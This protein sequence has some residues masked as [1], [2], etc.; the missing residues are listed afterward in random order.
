[1]NRITIIR[2]LIP[3][4]VCKRYTAGPSGLEKSVVAHVTEG[5]GKGFD[6]PDARAMVRVL[7]HVTSARNLVLVSGGWKNDSGQPFRVVDERKL[8][9]ILKGEVGRVPGG[10]IEH[11]GELISARLKRGIEAS[12]W[13][14]LDAD[15]PPGIPAEW[16]AMS[17][18][19]RLELWDKIIPGISRAERVELRGSSARVLNGS[20]HK[21]KTHA[22]VRVNKPANIGLMKAWIGVEMVNR[23]LSFQFEKKSR[24]TPDKT[25]GIE[26]RSVF[27]LAVFDTGRIVFCSEPE[28]DAP[29]YT[30]DDAGIEIV[31]EG[32][33]EVD[34]A[35][36]TTP[37]RSAL[38]EYKART[39]IELDVKVKD[40]GYLSVN[41]QGLLRHDTEITVRGVTKN[42]DEWV[43]GM[44]PGDKL[45]CESPFRESHSEAALVRLLDDGMPLVHDVGNGTTYTL[46]PEAIVFPTM[47]EFLAG[48]KG[49]APHPRI[50]LEPWASIE[51]T[52]IK[53]TVEGMLPAKGFAALYGQPGSY[54][55][56]VALYL[57]AMI[58]TGR[59]AFGRATQAG[60]IVYIMGEGGAGLRYRRDALTAEYGLPPDVP[61]HFIRAQLDLRSKTGDGK[62]LVEA[63]HGQGLQPSLVVIDTLAR[64]F[65]GG[66]E[67][68]SEDMGAFITQVGAVQE[69]LKCGILVVHHSGKDDARG[70]RGHSSLFGA[71]DAELEVKKQ[72][73]D[74]SADRYGTLAV[75]KQKDGEDGV[76]FGFR[77]KERQVT[78][79]QA[80]L[81]L[82][83]V[84]AG[85]AGSGA[86][87]KGRRGR[88]PD[89]P[90]I[91]LD[92]L[93]RAIDGHGVRVA[94]NEIPRDA[95]VVS[96]TLWRHTYNAMTPKEGEAARK[97][98]DREVLALLGGGRIRIWTEY[99]WIT[100]S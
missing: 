56:F 66:N 65:A 64:A 33:G 55:S 24:V 21:P 13:I 63:I 61:I 46:L 12:A 92:A 51:E 8:A 29:G 18:G 67:N 86:G 62:A 43:A 76:V 25:V 68:A 16:A 37:D 27:D 57:A 99:C 90:G 34:I 95:V 77:M 1:V 73:G 19:Q 42:L 47:E 50:R 80:S 100:K 26:A 2:S 39:G 89:N 41:A 70:M 75:S 23:G 40:D 58:A 7:E 9:D 3:D 59:E 74:D 11:E 14:L 88:K 4:T 69:A 38:N 6:V 83:P 20:G 78:L 87:A 98:F 91:A 17:I 79:D 36:M 5:V 84:D 97:A 30:L 32:G 96:R 52:K 22:W 10:V 44:K 94:N 93:Q 54:K 49:H 85:T 72:S 60:T 53:W 45:R 35:W 15:N 71:V 48:P 81:V 28:I 82:E 31:N